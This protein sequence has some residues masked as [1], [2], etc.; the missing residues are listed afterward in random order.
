MNKSI[1]VDIEKVE[2]ISKYKIYNIYTKRVTP[3]PHF[4]TVNNIGHYIV[5]HIKSFNLIATS[6]FQ[7]WNESKYRKVCDLWAE[8]MNNK[9]HDK[10]N[11]LDYEHKNG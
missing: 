6:S 7:N 11:Q 4:N 10:L 1:S 5:L 8:R 2:N 3:R 9:S